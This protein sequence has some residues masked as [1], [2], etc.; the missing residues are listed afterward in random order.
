MSK[1]KKKVKNVTPKEKNNNTKKDNSVINDDNL[2][3]TD[4]S[5][6][7]VNT[8]ANVK[9]ENLI[10]ENV[11]SEVITENNEDTTK[12][13]SN[14]IT[15]KEIEDI[16]NLTTSN[17]K[18]YKNIIIISIVSIIILALLLLFSTIFAL[19]NSNKDTIINGVNIKG[20][21]V[22]GLTKE[23][24][25][26][27]I[28]PVFE[29][30]LSKSI[31][32][33]HNEYELP[34]IFSQ[35]DVNF[36]LEEAVDLAYDKGRSGNIF[37][38]NFDIVIA[39]LSNI[40]INPG[41]SYSEDVID[42]LINE[43]EVNFEDRLIEPSYY[44]ENNNLVI[45]KGK[46]GIVI[47][48]EKL[49]SE[50]IYIVNNLNCDISQID[51][52]TQFKSAD[53]LDLNKIHEEIYRGPQDAYYT[54]DPYVIY[55]H[56]DGIDFSISM[57]E[58]LNIFNNTTDT[59][60]IPLKVL[61]PSVTT[62]Q[63]GKEAFPDLLATYSTT[64]STANVNRS[65]N[66]S[67]ASQKVN[68]TVVMPGE[69]FSYNTTVGQRTAAAGFKTAAVYSGGE[70]TTGIGGGICQ[71]SSTLYNAVLL[72]NLEIVER[73]NHGF[74]PGYV[75]AGRD[76]TVSWGGPDFKFKNTRDYPIKIVCS[77]S[78]G[79]IDFQIY[80]LKQENE[81]TVEIQS[82]ITRY[83]SYSTIQKE[84]NTLPIGETKVLQNGSNGC[85]SVAYRI[86]KS[87]GEVVSKTL[88]SQDTYNP[89]NKIVAVGTKEI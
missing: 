87:N 69:I 9:D 23:Q 85:K 24:A 28:S 36:S 4:T 17:K 13:E 3:S 30:N 50:I 51:I 12:T 39:L 5:S 42:S 21:D 37:K 84:D 10:E 8:L 22:S 65:T 38:N 58:A 81:Y 11:N 68:G 43:I 55:P 1:K 72:S 56:V 78:K 19:V 33:K 86:L 44:I 61:S 29:E 48:P 76:A 82:Y 25:L 52:P 14:E 6:E 89:H 7:D 47:V 15:D 75:P 32:L 88:L 54:T 16:E 64:Y 66:I 46:D 26:E 71:V 40:E 35:L 34:L 18:S 80:G 59:C 62:N 2:I 79:K 45:S 49:K 20:I 67:L 83:I 74:N 41:F 60:S 70:V 63:I 27:K 31:I 73:Y 57:E 53:I 77:A